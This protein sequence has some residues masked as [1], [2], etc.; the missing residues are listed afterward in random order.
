MGRLGVNVP[1][2]KIIFTK[3]DNTQILSR[4]INSKTK[5]D[6][7]NLKQS[8]LIKEGNLVNSEDMIHGHGHQS[9]WDSNKL[10]PDLFLN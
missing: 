10:H 6:I 8:K 9:N 4:M 7:I 3:A 2:K 1:L 5:G